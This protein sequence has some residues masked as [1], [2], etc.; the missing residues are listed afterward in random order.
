MSK[1]SNKLKE[2]FSA[3]SVDKSD[4]AKA[5]KM[6]RALLYRYLNDQSF[7]TFS[8][9]DAVSKELFLTPYEYKELRSAYELTQLGDSVCENRSIVR[10]IIQKLY[11][12][13]SHSLEKA[14][15]N[16]TASFQKYSP[17]YDLKKYGILCFSDT[18]NVFSVLRDII[19][20]ADTTEILM[21][22]QPDR[23]IV[24]NDLFALLQ[25]KVCISQI[26]IEHI[27][28]F[29]SKTKDSIGAYNLRMFSSILPFLY[30]CT[31]Y[32]D[33]R[34][35][36]Y[37]YYNNQAAV[38]ERA[39]EI[40][41]N[42]FITDW[43]VCVMSFD[44]DSCIVYTDKE[45]AAQYQCCFNQIK[46][47]TTPLVHKTQSNSGSTWFIDRLS[48]ESVSEYIFKR[49][50]SVSLGIPEDY[51]ETRRGTTKEA[52]DIIQYHQQYTHHKRKLHSS[53]R[54]MGRKDF[55]TSAGLRNFME[56]GLFY[57]PLEDYM[58]PL[59]LQKRYE[60]IERY[61]TNVRGNDKF[62]THLVKTATLESFGGDFAIYIFNEDSL[63]FEHTRRK[64]PSDY[65][66]ETGERS[67]IQAFYEYLNHGIVDGE[68]ILTKEK[69]LDYLQAILDE[70]T[71]DN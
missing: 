26:Q 61:I 37:Y 16:A 7:P 57:T 68:E 31:Y 29:Q 10:E 21:S 47:H 9:V 54:F 40:Y 64:V 3:K 41:P 19:Y 24:T 17:E 62:S 58:E 28:R 22:L 50:P 14:V 33:S 70:H 66:I 63:M 18:D 23:S 15:K 11:R 36:A 1:F 44:Y 34:Y 39:M 2:I 20:D 71:Y 52:Q 53:A 43:C 59:S 27:L 60:F 51:Y 32:T 35:L 48:T 49:H 25:N 65:V 46:E 13:S 4:V 38:D 8:F 55:F 12:C 67:I 42:I 45:M 6:E 30:T 69:S 5:L 56:T